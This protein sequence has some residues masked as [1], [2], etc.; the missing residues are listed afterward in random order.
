[1]DDLDKILYGDEELPEY[2]GFQ[3]KDLASADWAVR[4]AKAAEA[5]MQKRAELAEEYRFKIDSWLKDSN[6]SDLATVEYMAGVLKP[7]V[8][9]ELDGQ[10]ARTVKLPSGDVGLRKLPEKVEIGDESALLAHLEAHFPECVRIKKEVDKTALKKLIGEEGNL[11][12]N[13]ESLM[14]RVSGGE[15]RLYIK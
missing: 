14:A 6:K 9:A 12:V 3:V 1:M 5:R 15:E 7:F 4:K 13:G 8:V 2:Q 11:Y 10:K